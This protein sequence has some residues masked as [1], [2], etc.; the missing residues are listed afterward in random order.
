ML[1]L[2]ARWNACILD[3]ADLLIPTLRG[4]IR[5]GNSGRKQRKWPGGHLRDERNVRIEVARR[6]VVVGLG[7]NGA[8]TLENLT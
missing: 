1:S 3:R 2:L 7:E 6:A 4:K 5:N 8:W